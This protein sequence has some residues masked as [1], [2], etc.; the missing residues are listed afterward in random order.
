MVY[1]ADT[2]GAGSYEL[3]MKAGTDTLL[4]TVINKKGNALP[5]TGKQTPNL[6]K[7][8]LPVVAM[9]EALMLYMYGSRGRRRRKKGVNGH[10][11]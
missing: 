3:S 1:T 11:R 10:G 6:P 8:V 4:M 2:E 5:K 9:V 7:A